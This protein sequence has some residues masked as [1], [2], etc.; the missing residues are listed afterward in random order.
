MTSRFQRVFGAGKPVIAMV[1]LAALPGTPLHD[2][3]RGDRGHPRA[4]PAP[5]CDALQAAGV[6]AVMF[7]NEND[8]PYELEVDAAATAT[9]AYVIGRLRDE[10]ARAVRGQ[11][12]LG[13]AGDPGARR[14]DR[15]ALRAR[16]LHRRLRLRHGP[17]GARCREPRRAT[18]GWSARRDVVH[19]LQRLG[20]VRALARR[21]QP[22]RPSPL[23][24][25]LVGAGRGARLGH[26]SPAR[27]RR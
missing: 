16:D 23:G 5:T 2:A 14:G 24:G 22:A 11:R 21:T 1:H 10:I 12:P 15:R 6:D 4:A 9:M 7:G 27:P 17:L 20:R 13:P 25:L 18:A 26:R 8:R 3:E 19:A